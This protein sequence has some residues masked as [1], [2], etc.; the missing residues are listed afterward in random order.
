MKFLPLA[1]KDLRQ[2][3][4]VSLDE[5]IHLFL[6]LPIFGKSASPAPA[7]SS[8]GRNIIL[9]RDASTVSQ[10]RSVPVKPLAVFFGGTLLT[11][12]LLVFP[13]RGQGPAQSVSPSVDLIAPTLRARIDQIAKQV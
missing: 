1:R 12:S 11:A 8:H 5:P 4:L 2:K 9:L 7:Y 10:R 13:A 6:L 3:L